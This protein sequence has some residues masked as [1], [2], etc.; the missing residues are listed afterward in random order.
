MRTCRSVVPVP[1]RVPRPWLCAVEPW[2]LAGTN[3]MNVLL[4]NVMSGRPQFVWLNTLLASMRS[5]GRKRP[6]GN[7]RN[8]PRSTFHT[9]GVRNWLRRLV[10]KPVRP[11]PVG[12]ENADRS[13][14]G[15]VAEP[16][17]PVGLGLPLTLMST[18]PQPGQL[19]AALL[20]VIENGVPE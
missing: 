3:R 20:P 7:D 2:A 15:V 9:G 18:E 19:R 1:Q 17:W 12:C 11:R 10:P 13:Y 4:V 16:A 5:S 6:T 14:H 8:R